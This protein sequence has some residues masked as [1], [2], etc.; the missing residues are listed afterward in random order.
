[1]PGVWKPRPAPGVL[2]QKWLSRR[3]PLLDPKFGHVLRE[4]RPRPRWPRRGSE[5][6]SKVGAHGRERRPW[7]WQRGGR[8]LR[9]QPTAG[10]L[11]G[12]GAT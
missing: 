6:P 1:M 5:R 9:R 11:S 2:G 10:A 7:P 3:P 12:G 8:P 4:G